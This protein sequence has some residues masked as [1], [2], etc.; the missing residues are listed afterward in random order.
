MRLVFDMETDGLWY[1]VT[2][3]HCAVFYDIDTKKYY[4]VKKIEN[5]VKMLEKCTFLIGWNIISYDLP[6]IKKLTGYEYRGEKFDGVLL[7][8]ELYKNRPVH[9]QMKL[10]Y[11]AAKKKLDG[12]HSLAAWGYHVGIGKVEIDDWSNL[13]FEEYAKRCKFDVDIT[14]LAY[15]DLRDKLEKSKDIFPVRSFKL[16]QDFMDCI[17]R[18]EKWG[19][20]LDIP[21]C[22]RYVKQL[23]KWVR[24]I[25]TVLYPYVPTLPLIKEDRVDDSGRSEGFKNPFTKAGSIN[26]R[27]AKWIESNEIPWTREEI[28]GP[29]CR[30]NFRKVNLGSDK[31]VKEWLLDM[32]W[33]PEEYNY[34]KTERDEDGNPKRT[35]PK[36]SADDMFY[37]IDGKIGKLICKR[38]QCRHR[39][40]NIQGWL[41]RVRP[42]GR[43]ESRISGF[44]DTYRVRHASVANVPNTESFFGNQMRKCFI[45]EEGMT[46]VSAD[47]ASCQDRMLIARAR[48]A[49]I[50]DPLFEE[51]ILRGDKKKGTDSHTRA[52][53]ELNKV[54]EAEGLPTITRGGAK[55]FNYAYKFNAGNKK[56]G[57]MAG[58]MNETQAKALG[59]K[60]RG[61]LDE[62]FKAQV[63]LE[64]HLKK[65][66][67]QTA[68]SRE[69]T[70]KKNGREF[71]RTEF[72]N[73]RVRGLD[74]R[75]ILIRNEKDILV[76]MLQ[77]DEALTMTY[78]T[79]LQNKWFRQK[80]KEGVDYKQVCM[81][82][83]E[84][85]V[86]C[87]PEIAEDIGEMMERAINQAGKYFK[88]S[89]EQNG[90]AAI[91]KS[92]QAVH[93]PW[94][95]GGLLVL[96]QMVAYL[97]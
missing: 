75:Q 13:S 65:E 61:A 30:V 89:I 17:S 6:V 41:E 39:Q 62:V 63:E 91:G 74:G 24:W 76:F 54:F 52:M 1:D 46:L 55:N 71:K 66:W 73:G 22:E 5:V 96:Q 87:R 95:V 90:E 44:A 68:R 53:Q 57:T 9:P 51:M 77:S 58:V 97:T 88:L 21:R 15:L 16:T 19:W 4:T 93:S 83:D 38:V 7:S 60:L 64:K 67:M 14:Y 69:V 35:S 11:E 18:Q 82:H 78:S 20:K 28:G 31:E 3:M 81:Y 47:A 92:W 59:E 12:P 34:S 42:D 94:W 10:D 25:D 23:E 40:S 48:D 84:T 26:A 27:L 36:L 86:E 29:F 80:Y 56:L 50:N 72:Y 45:A 85:T 8:R 49:G 2:K 79:V 37:G 43:I 32:G 70:F 33:Q